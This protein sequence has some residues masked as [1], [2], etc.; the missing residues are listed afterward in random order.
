MIETARTIADK[1]H[2]ELTAAYVKQPQIA[3]ADEAAL[4]EKIGIAQDAGACIE[5][6]EGDDP[7]NAILDYA[8]SRGITQ[9]FVGHSQRS[10]LRPRLWGNPVDKLVRLSRGMDVRIFPQS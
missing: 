4:H 1:F 9:L 5:I 8:K 7:V 10:G 6:L 2:G 3:P